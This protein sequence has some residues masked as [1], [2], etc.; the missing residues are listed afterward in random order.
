MVPAAAA[1]ALPPRSPILRGASLGGRLVG[2]T[3]GF[4]PD[5]G[6]SSPSPP[7]SRRKWQLVL[8]RHDGREELDLRNREDLKSAAALARQRVELLE[9][10]DLLDLRRA[11]AVRADQQCMDHDHGWSA[12]GRTAAG[13]LAARGWGLQPVL[14]LGR[15]AARLRAGLRCRALR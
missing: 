15:H 8:P 10:S 14:L 9:G 7:A 6:G 1:T 2:R 3:S 13:W 11:V 5:N 12:S 4:G